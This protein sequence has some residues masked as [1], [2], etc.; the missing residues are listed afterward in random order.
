MIGGS[1]RARAA[2]PNRKVGASHWWQDGGGLQRRTC[3]RGQRNRQ[4]Q[5]SATVEAIS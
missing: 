4:A 3:F 1:L 5:Q 2:S